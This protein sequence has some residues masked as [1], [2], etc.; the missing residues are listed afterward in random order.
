MPLVT[1]YFQLHQPLRLH[2]EKGESLWEQRN[3]EVFLKVSQRCYLPATRMFT[4]LVA[5]YP[6]FKVCLGLSGTFLEQAE[7]YDPEVLVALHGLYET[8]RAGDQVELLDE[9]FYHS[10]ASLFDDESKSEFQEQVSLHRQEVINLLGVK[11]TA[12]RNTELI[13]NNEIANVVADMG[14]Q[15]MLCEQCPGPSLPGPGGPMGRSSVFRPRGRNGRPRKL[16]VL[17]RNRDLSDE[18]GLRYGTAPVTAEQYAASLAEAAGEVLVLGYDYEHIGEHIEVETGIFTFWR[19]LAQLM[20]ERSGITIANPSQIAGRFQD[21]DCPVLDVP[22]SATSSWSDAKQGTDRWLGSFTQ[23]ALFQDL[24]ALEPEVRNAGGALL[25]RYRVLTGSDH[26]YYLQEGREAGHW[27]QEALSPYGSQAAAAFVLTRAMD[28]LRQS[29]KT[30][31]VR[32]TTERTAVI[33]VTPET[34]RLP[35]TGMGQFARFVSGKSGGMGEVVSALCKGLAERRVPVHLITLNL[36]RRFREEAGLSEAE[37]AQKRHRINPENVHLVT[38]SLYEDYRSAYDGNPLNNA[39][40]FQKQIVNSY[41]VDILSRYEGRALLHSNDWMAGGIV[42][43]Y[44]NLR[45][46][47]VLHTVHNTHTGC[48][49]VDLFGGV[50]LQKVWDRLYRVWDNGRDCVDAQATAIKN[51]TKISYVGHRFLTEVIENHFPDRAVI[52][53]SV[54]QETKAKFIS[55]AALV[56]PNGISPDL[57]PENQSE[58]PRVDQPGLARRFGPRDADLVGAKRANLVKFQQKTGLLVNPDAVLLYW[59][60]RLDPA[61][62]GIELLE[63]I[64]QRFVET[65]PAVQIAVIGDPVGGDPTHA[66][67]MGRI[68]YASAGRIAYRR[69]DEDLSVL[70]YAAASDVFGA[71]LYEP[72]GQIDVIGNIYGATATNRDTGGYADKISPLSIRA[73]GAP[74]DRGN[75]VLFK[76]YNAE[77]LWWGLRVAVENHQ[78]LCENPHEWERQMRR[79][80]RQARDTWSLEN[81]VAG[82]MMAYEQLN[83]GR[84]LA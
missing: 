45:G 76:D 19:D 20:S 24:Q 37:W 32:K 28:H 42:T 58:G 46:V 13:Y 65:Y 16:I 22:V 55:G 52:P 17:A 68:A 69:F 72:F 48:I 12:F 41:V 62:K 70:G 63:Q 75:G 60:S 47:P 34:A 74:V 11:P 14:Y 50:S 7:R 30:F 27:T 53:A 78:Y 54:R 64:A 15:V 80:M 84:P 10:L 9:T 39:A 36:A 35:S 5:R 82:Y 6:G 56:I 23:R 31:N 2:M 18:V 81:M 29:V 83:G 43:A 38:S 57:F 59:P 67:I 61:Q 49:P 79:I 77:G 26:W 44:A 71:S 21:L 40:D 1:F 8:G 33:I 66:E 3:R 51:A 4:E 25:R 73:W